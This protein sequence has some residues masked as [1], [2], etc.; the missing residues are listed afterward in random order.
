VIFL[1]NCRFSYAIVA[2]VFFI[3]WAVELPEFTDQMKIRPPVAAKVQIRRFFRTILPACAVLLA[4]IVVM[5]SILVYKISHPGAIPEATNPYHYLLPSLEVSIP[6]TGGIDIGGWWIPGQ[7]NSPGI[8]LAPGYGMNRADA[9]SLAAALNNAGFNLLVY[10]QRGS[11]IN[12]KEASTLGLYEADDM[13]AA[14]RY[15]QSRP[16]NNSNKLGIWGVD[17]GARAALHA[18]A[19]FPQVQAIVADSAYE[20]VADFL[21]YRIAEDFGLDNGL[22]QFCCYQIFKLAHPGRALSAVDKLPLRALSNR[23]ILFIKGENRKGLASFTAGI[24]S[25]IQPQKEMI[26][27]KA[28]RTH[29]MDLEDLKSYDMQVASFFHLNLH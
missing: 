17:I 19:D 28:S 1:W 22:A 15:M 26:S 14:L 3:S 6:S 21:N 24:Y 5:L 20:A 12:S 18:A 27:L 4:G 10:C 16:E 13:S 2:I 11:G 7:K 8:I 9:L 25:Q 29:M 23:T